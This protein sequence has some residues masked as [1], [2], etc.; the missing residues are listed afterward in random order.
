MDLLEEKTATMETQYDYIHNSI[1]RLLSRESDIQESAFA[2]EEYGKN[3]GEKLQYLTYLNVLHQKGDKNLILYL[4][5]KRLQNKKDLLDMEHNPLEYLTDLDDV[6]DE[7]LFIVY[8]DNFNI[9]KNIP[10]KE[11]LYS[12]SNI[13]GFENFNKKAIAMYDKQKEIEVPLDKM[14]KLV[15]FKINERENKIINNIKTDDIKNSI[16]Y[17]VQK[18]MDHDVIDNTVKL[19]KE[20][21]ENQEGLK[22]MKEHIQSILKEGDNEIARKLGE[23]SN[24]PV[25]VEEIRTFLDDENSGEI[26]N[27]INDLYQTIVE[28]KGLKDKTEVKYTRK[29][30]YIAGNS[31]SN[32]IFPGNDKNFSSLLR[33]T[34]SLNRNINEN[35]LKLVGGAE[36]EKQEKKE[37]EIGK[38]ENNELDKLQKV[39]SK[40]TST[41]NNFP[42]YLGDELVFTLKNAK[43]IIGNILGCDI[44][45][46]IDTKSIR[47]SEDL[48]CLLG[49]LRKL[50]SRS[51]DISYIEK[52]KLGLLNVLNLN[53]GDSLTKDKIGN[54]MNILQNIR[55]M[56]KKK[57]ILEQLDILVNNNEELKEMK[58]YLLQLRDR[59]DWL[60]KNCKFTGDKSSIE[61]VEVA[62]AAE[63]EEEE[64]KD[65]GDY[66]EDIIKSLLLS[67]IGGNKE[68]NIITPP[69]PENTE[70][71]P[72]YMLSSNNKTSIIEKPNVLPISADSLS[73]IENT[74]LLPVPT[75]KELPVLP[76]PLDKNSLLEKSTPTIEP[77]QIPV[78]ID[79]N[80]ENEN[81]LSVN[82]PN[83]IDNELINK[84]PLKVNKMKKSNYNSFN[85]YNTADFVKEWNRTEKMP[86]NIFLLQD[87]AINKYENIYP[88]IKNKD[89]LHKGGNLKEKIMNLKGYKKDRFVDKENI[90]NIIYGF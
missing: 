23:I 19:L 74:N 18:N 2:L 36:Q 71:L 69:L 10:G 32:I 40:V 41:N 51:R 56:D 59:N 82:V 42:I 7:D 45:G 9:L 31:I 49:M 57:D 64:N 35:N 72:L 44:E 81:K 76:V 12:F 62:E 14:S 29:N 66:D 33:T 89:D 67:S 84:S 87:K 13:T 46:M 75:V 78:I 47:D 37:N 58:K 77:L 70:V 50:S 61:E 55:N 20:F 16:D 22:Q 43:R 21:K 53:E 79:T 30:F 90:V 6:S 52:I 3:M 65:E 4:L 25:K 68:N 38:I 63:E 24:V 86:Y 26:K 83:D 15:L 54:L 60:E 28:D 85:P 39:I 11:N 48:N 80:L 34:V 17:L 1:E 73:H 8:Y 27:L 5:G 88:Y